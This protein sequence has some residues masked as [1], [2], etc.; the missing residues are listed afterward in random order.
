MQLILSGPAVGIWS[1]H[2]LRTVLSS[3][4]HGDVRT[5]GHTGSFTATRSGSERNEG[6]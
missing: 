3:E 1:E 5:I 6:V 4:M 2:L